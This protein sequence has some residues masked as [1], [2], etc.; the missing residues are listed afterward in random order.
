MQLRLEPTDGLRQHG[1]PL[2]VVYA[3]NV[4]GLPDGHAARIQ[5][6]DYPRDLWSI[7][8]S[9]NG[10]YEDNPTGNYL[11]AEDALAVLQDEYK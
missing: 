4:C 8:R 2:D 3:Y 10:Q 1:R 9:R 7:L 5:N 6:L 11:S